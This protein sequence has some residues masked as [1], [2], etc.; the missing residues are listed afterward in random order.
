MKRFLTGKGCVAPRILHSW[1][2]L[3]QNSV[4]TGF[5]AYEG[6]EYIFLHLD[7]FIY[8]WLTLF[9]PFIFFIIFKNF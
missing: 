9:F 7:L 1:A 8:F 3:K 5:S 2:L 4:S 6:E